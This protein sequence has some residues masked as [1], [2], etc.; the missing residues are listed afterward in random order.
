MVTRAAEAHSPARRRRTLDHVKTIELIYCD[1]GGGHRS[2]AL[3]LSEIA[4]RQERPW[5]VRMT[6]LL[7]LFAAFDFWRRLTGAGV[8]DAYNGMLRRGWTLGTPML[9]RVMHSVVR[10]YHKRQVEALALHWERE[11]PDAVVSFIPHFNRGLD[12][13]IRLV[14]PQVPLVTILT[15]LADYPPHFWIEE[16]QEQY[17]VCGTDLARRQ[18]LAAGHPEERVFHTS[19]MIL[20]PRFYDPAPEAH[21]GDLTALG[22]DPSLPTALMMFGGAGSAAMRTIARLLDESDLGVQ[23]IAVCGRNAR[24]EASLARM[25]RRIPMHVTGFTSDVARLMR[26]S[27]FF[28]GK[29]G[30]GS[31]SEAVA[32]GLPVI[33]ERNAWTLPQER[34]NADWVAERGFGIAVRSFRRE[35]VGAVTTMID[36]HRYARFAERV[37]GFRNQAV[38]EI[39]EI[40]KRILAEPAVPAM[41]GLPVQPVRQLHEHRVR[42]MQPHQVPDVTR[43][44]PRS[45]ASAGRTLPPLVPHDEQRRSGLVLPAEHEVRLELLEVEAAG[46]VRDRR[47]AV[48]GVPVV[49]RD[50]ARRGRQLAHVRVGALRDERLHVRLQ[51]DVRREGVVEPHGRRRRVLVEMRERVVRDVRR[52][53]VVAVPLVVRDVVRPVE[54]E[55]RA[56]AAVDLVRRSRAPGSY[57]ALRPPLPRK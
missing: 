12:E 23:V 8:E 54:R 35:I 27:D 33:I 44:N 40:L 48:R 32:M 45:P 43:R 10:R 46:I 5:R 38:F 1:A 7:E 14:M 15:D 39:P 37:S 26:L 53:G 19:G 21:P 49:V 30:P 2:A 20:N 11:R 28:I 18:A 13:A 31:I 29:A 57:D 51:R 52:V 4:R 9:L 50:R 41:P 36:P 16:G 56:E 6:N 3:A 42:R 47:V 25:P 24:L 17:F 34:Y 22:L 55:R